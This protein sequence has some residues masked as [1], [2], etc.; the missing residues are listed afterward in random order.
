MP[1]RERPIAPEVGQT[2]RR[3]GIALMSV[4]LL[5]VGSPWL[6]Q[7]VYELSEGE[8]LQEFDIFRKAPTLKHIKSFED[9]LAESAVVAELAR[10]YTQW[11]ALTLTGQGNEKVVIGRDGW[12]FYRPGLLYPT[13]TGFRSRY[14]EEDAEVKAW[15]PL[16]AIVKFYEDLASRGIELVIVPIP[17]KPQ[18]YPEKLTR[19]Y[20][21]SLGPPVNLYQKE[22]F[23][24][25]RAEGI[26]V[27][28]LARR[29]WEAKP[30]GQL[31]MALD[32]HWTPLG[33]R[34]FADALAEE[35]RRRFA[36]LKQSEREYRSRPVR[37]TN[38][39][40]IFDMLKLPPWSRAYTTREIAVEQVADAEPDPSSPVVLLGDS[41]TNVFSLKEMKWGE[42]AGLGEHLMMRLG[43]PLDVIAVN[44]G[45]PTATR[46]TLARERS[47]QGK[48]LVV[49]SFATRELIIP[50]SEWAI[51]PLPEAERK[52][53][54]AGALEVVAEVLIV[55]N[56]PRPGC[57]PLPRGDYFHQIQGAQGGEGQL[58]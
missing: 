38:R 12:L 33:M 39:G 20:D 23:K 6:V 29:L 31:Y 11:I 58:R 43:R 4:F 8:R 41:F 35:L 50:D 7:F 19:L 10:P 37:M 51:V 5:M 32:T 52:A 48:R 17:V 40:D 55:S 15:D 47:L 53:P 14:A 22:F 56:P 9:E 36:W 18:V 49:W 2:D 13:G 46:R 45:A 42:R 34:I 57:R 30:Q 1:V 26:G 44:G 27:I 21:L 28:D 24:D 54:A 25:L 16:P 3:A